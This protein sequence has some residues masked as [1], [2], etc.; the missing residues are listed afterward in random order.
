M[1]E[2]VKM[3]NLIDP[4]ATGGNPMPVQLIP[5]PDIEQLIV[6]VIVVA[7]LMITCFVLGAKLSKG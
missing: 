7:A 4:P 3:P 6:A 5:V 2:R 1:S